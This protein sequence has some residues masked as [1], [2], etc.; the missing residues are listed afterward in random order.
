MRTAYFLILLSLAH[1]A[2]GQDIA[3]QSS[4][5]KNPV[6]QNERFTLSFT[7]E[8]GGRTGLPKFPDLTKFYILGGPNQSSSMQF[9][10]GAMSSSVT[11][12]FVLQPRGRGKY[13]VGPASI[14][15]GGKT[16]STNSIT[17]EVV[18]GSP[19][20]KPQQQPRGQT[21]DAAVEAESQIAEN[22]FLKAFVDKANVV[23]G[24]QVTLTF[25]IYSRVNAGNYK[26]VKAPPI[27]GFWGEVIEEQ[28]PIPPTKETINGKQYNVELINYSM[29]LFPTQTGPLEVGPM[30]IEA[31]VQVRSRSSDPFE[32][33]FQ[34]P[35]GQQVRYVMKS[36]PVKV[37]VDPL[38]ADAPSGFKGAVGSFTMNTTL[39]KTKTVTN[40]PVSL[41][42]TVGGTGNIK[43]LESPQVE[44][45][46]DFEQY[47]PKVSENISRQML[48]KI[49][50]SKTF[51][52]LLIPRYPGQKHIKPVR[53]VYFDLAKRKYVT[54]NSEEYVLD[55][56]QGAVTTGPATSL[57]PR[58]DVELLTQDIRFI[59]VTDGGLA[60]RN[61]FVHTSGGFIVL[62]LLPLLA[63]G[64][65]VMFARQRKTELADEAGY[66]NRRAIKIA[67]KGLKQADA[68]LNQKVVMSS[69]Q[70]VKFYS[71]ISTALWKYLGDKLN[72]SI[73]DLSIDGTLEELAKR[74]VNGGL[75]S[76]LKSLLESCEMARFA[77]TGIEQTAMHRTYDEAKRIIVELER[78]LRVR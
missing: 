62:L 29:A 24:E 33:F 40:E 71:E 68:I 34:N 66:R 19:K 16:Y 59:K 35:F 75:S 64:G 61:Q 56:E 53:F 8:N 43:L 26:L 32:A 45:P 20:P 37:R 74:S 18:R 60:R 70:K 67:N 4:V 55:V 23:Q 28:N 15:I 73:A 69:E 2:F 10:N 41:K 17:I 1:S 30:E 44:I 6:G 54:L 39:D 11:Y 25:K 21:A 63:F 51:E 78:N 22:L 3:F 36:A 76:S 50:G 31:A 47:S 14:E 49:S 5:D 12:S 52:H 57:V 38:P 72:I 77:P 7:L 48:K 13:T 65:V 42:I 27:T 58:S 46:P 9:I